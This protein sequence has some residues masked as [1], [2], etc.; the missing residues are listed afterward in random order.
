MLNNPFLAGV[1]AGIPISLLC[2]GYVAV[3][4]DEVVRLFTE[5]SG[6]EALS[7]G[8]ATALAFGAAACIGPGL[9]LLAAFVHGW[10]PSEGAYVALALALATLFSVAAVASRT[11][12][13]VEKVV[14]N[15]AVAIALGVVAPRL[16][17]G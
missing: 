5:G 16:I 8:A 6:S 9:G 17:G 15:F 12:L 11:P 4:R 14:L 1:I 10:L 3:R 13:M 2:L 7:P